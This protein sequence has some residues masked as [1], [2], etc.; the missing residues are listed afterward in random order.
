MNHTVAGIITCPSN[1][2]RPG[3]SMAFGVLL[4]CWA[5]GHESAKTNANDPPAEAAAQP[6]VVPPGVPAD[7]KLILV[8]VALCDNVNQGIV[9]VPAR[10]GNGD[11]PDGNLYWGAAF[12]LKTY[13]NKTSGWRK[14]AQIDNP[15]TAI[16]QRCVFRYRDSNTYMVSDAYRGLEIRRGISDFLDYAAGASL[17]STNLTSLPS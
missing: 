16:L 11:D 3:L 5:C 1:L 7:V 15:R 14:L 13:F 12:G 9:P 2:M 17:E 6:T 8:V 10:L 4:V